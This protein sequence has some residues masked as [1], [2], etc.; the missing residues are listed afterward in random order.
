MF[1]AND[2]K[3]EAITLESDDKGDSVTLLVKLDGHE[4]KIACGRGTWKKG[5]MAYGM[6]PEQPAAASGAW[7]ADDTF[8]A[9][10][11]LLRDAVYCHAHL[12]VSGRRAAVRFAVERGLRRDQATTARGQS[13]RELSSCR[14][15]S[16]PLRSRDETGCR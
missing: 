14:I 10:D 16:P 2:R 13:G 8:T 7:T 11:L 1:P 3:L 4:Q 6:L 15:Q 12:E 9:K 5:E